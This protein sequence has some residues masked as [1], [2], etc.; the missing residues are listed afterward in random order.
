MYKRKSRVRKEGNTIAEM[1]RD[2]ESDDNL[3]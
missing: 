3:I 2:F 1:A